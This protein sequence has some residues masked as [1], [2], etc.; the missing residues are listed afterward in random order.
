MNTIKKFDKI[1]CCSESSY[2]ISKKHINSVTFVRN[3]NLFIEDN[4]DISKIRIQTR[5]M[6][7]IP[8]D[9]KVYIFIGN[10]NKNKNVIKMLS[11]FTKS[12]NKD[13]Y[14]IT[15]GNGELYEKCKKFSSQRIL[16]LGYANSILKYLYASDIYTS[17]SLTEGFSMSI[18]EALHCGLLLLVS[19][20]DSHI[21]CFELEKDKYIGEYFDTESF[22]RFKY[23]KEIVSAS[24]RND[25]KYIQNKYLSSNSMTEGYERIYNEV[26]SK[27]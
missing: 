22:E 13:E 16:Q 26:F 27:S 23:A 1:V 8:L 11:Y 3:G 15:L 18:I 21:E 2:R 17:F 25:S 5:K 4:H 7:N 12:L 19:N 6:L 20:I 24:N 14:L 9:S 10:Y